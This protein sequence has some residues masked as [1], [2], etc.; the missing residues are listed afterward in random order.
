METPTQIAS[1]EIAA[2][3]ADPICRFARLL[4]HQAA[5]EYLGALGGEKRKTPTDTK[6]TVSV[7]ENHAGTTK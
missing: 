2:R 3:R 5:R 1:T 6:N 4:A 7:Q